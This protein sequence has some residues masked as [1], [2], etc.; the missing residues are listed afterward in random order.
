LFTTDPK[1]GGSLKTTLDVKTQN[2]AEAAMVGETRR[3]ALVAIRVSDGALLAVANGPGAAGNNFAL[4]GQTPPGSTFKTITALGVLNTGQIGLDT[5]VNCPQTLTVAGHTFR[6]AHN[7]A[8]GNVTFRVDFAKS[9]NTAFASL[10]DRLGGDG[11]SK[12]AQTV[13]IGV[14]WDV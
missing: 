9:C 10:A 13:G 2:A 11:L 5:P 4:L 12:T 8:L 1:P 14:P 7:M 3:S 6:N